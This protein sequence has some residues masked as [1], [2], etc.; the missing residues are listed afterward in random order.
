MWIY[1]D[2]LHTYATNMTLSNH[3]THA[4]RFIDFDAT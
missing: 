2:M 4:F 1:R 3:K